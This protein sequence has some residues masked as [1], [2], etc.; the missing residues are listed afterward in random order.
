MKTI[1][2]IPTYNEAENVSAITAELL[3]LDT[4]GLEVLII[5]DNSP[6]GTGKIVDELAQRCYPER[7]HVIHRSGLGHETHLR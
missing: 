7:L 1:I 6:D 4:D 2:V 5:D 3:T